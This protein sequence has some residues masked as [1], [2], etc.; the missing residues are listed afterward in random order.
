[1]DRLLSISQV[2]TCCGR[3]DQVAENLG[4]WLKTGIDELILVDWGCPQRTAETLAEIRHNPKHPLHDSARDPRL[5]L[6]RVPAKL[7]GGYFNLSK[8]RNRGAEEARHP[9]LFFLDADCVAS[10]LLVDLARTQMSAKGQA[11]DLLCYHPELLQQVQAGDYS[12]PPTWTQDG[13]CMIRNHAFMGVRGYSELADW[14]GESYDLYLRIQANRKWRVGKMPAAGLCC[15]SHP[16]S[17]RGRRLVKP[18]SDIL[19]AAMRFEENS[20]KLAEIRGSFQQRLSLDQ[21]RGEYSQHQTF[22]QVA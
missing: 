17:E 8:A 3:W 6:L 21:I 22:A 9:V 2:T 11:D 14:G 19:A 4:K 10:D 15:Y 13:Q 7:T 20:Q 5:R 18:F 1:M 16:D 12:L